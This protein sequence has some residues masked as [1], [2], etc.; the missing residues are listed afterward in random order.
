MRSVRTLADALA[1]LKD[2][3]APTAE[4]ALSD[5][6]LTQ[7]LNDNQLATVWAANTEYEF[8]DRIV[9][10]VP[11]GRVYAVAQNQA[12]TFGGRSGATEP[13][14]WPV[15]RRWPGRGAAFQDDGTLR[16]AD[17]GTEMGCLWDLRNSTHDAWMKK[18]ALASE[19]HQTGAD[20]ATFAAQQVYEHCLDMARR[21][22]PF[23]IN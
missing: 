3:C 5:A 7:V 6:E 17:D 11:N 19:K 23:G 9:P 14:P 22:A 16:W 1:L 20:R 18:A 12:G 4:P 13:S 8:G 15:F 21:Y 10:T 2:A